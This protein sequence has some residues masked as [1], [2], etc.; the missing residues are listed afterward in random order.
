M[1]NEQYLQF[2]L[3]LYA[4]GT[5]LCKGRVR[6]KGEN[7]PILQNGPTLGSCGEEH[8]LCVC[9]GRMEERLL[10]ESLDRGQTITVFSISITLNRLYAVD[11]YVVLWSAFAA[12]QRA[13]TLV[14]FWRKVLE[15]TPVRICRHVT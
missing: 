7:T 6:G 12:L 14:K 15:C 9:G 13:A 11:L 3:S 2:G 4:C 10:R 8:V 5:S 1:K